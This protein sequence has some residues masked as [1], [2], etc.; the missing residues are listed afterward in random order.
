MNLELLKADYP[1]C[2]ITV[3]NRL[4]YYEALDQ[5]MVHGKTKPFIQLVT[6]T[7]LEGFKPYQVVLGI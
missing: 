2:V 6:D 5:W 4:S 7:V 3:E 1:A